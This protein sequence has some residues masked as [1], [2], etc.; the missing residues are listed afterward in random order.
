ME[1]EGDLRTAALEE[2]GELAPEELGVLVVALRGVV[3][4]V[5]LGLEEVFEGLAVVAARRGGLAAAGDGAEGVGAA[6]GPDGGEGGAGCCGGGCGRVAGPAV[7]VVLVVVLAVVAA[8]VG[9][10]VV[11]EDEARVR[12]HPAGLAAGAEVQRLSVCPRRVPRDE[13]VDVGN[14]IVG[15]DFEVVG[16]YGGGVWRGVGCGLVWC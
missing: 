11:V 5:G 3:V 8:D 1:R 14:E 12:R 6:V 13:P 16:H 7:K 2:L 4:V 10:A 9:V 15:V